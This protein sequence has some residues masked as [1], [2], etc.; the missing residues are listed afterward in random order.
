M[1]NNVFYD[2]FKYSLESMKENSVL[3]L[4]TNDKDYQNYTNQEEIAEAQ[5]MQLNL[6]TEQKEIVEQLLDARDRQ[7]IEYSNLSYL[8]GVIDCIKFLKCFNIP[9]D[10][11]PKD[12]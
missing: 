2:M 1:T 12:E 10:A 4:L 6:S 9:I 5:Y 7:G 8:A 3:P 11:M